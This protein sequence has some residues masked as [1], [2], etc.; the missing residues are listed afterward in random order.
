MSITGLYKKFL[1]ASINSFPGERKVEVRRGC[2]LNEKQNIW[3]EW[4]VRRGGLCTLS[5]DGF[6]IHGFTLQTKLVKNLNFLL[7]EKNIRVTSS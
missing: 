3:R 6:G 4:G 1:F 2:Y 5:W 7:T